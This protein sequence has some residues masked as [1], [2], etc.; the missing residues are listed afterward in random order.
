MCSYLIEV[1]FAD[2]RLMP[3][4]DTF[5]RV[6]FADRT[7][8]VLCEPLTLDRSVFA[9]ASGDI[10]P[11]NRSADKSFTGTR[12]RSRASS[13]RRCTR[14]VT[15]C[16][17]ATSTSSICTTTRALLSKVLV[18]LI[19]I[20]CSFAACSA[21]FLF[22]CVVFGCA[23]INIF[24]TL[25]NN[26][27]EKLVYD[28]LRGMQAMGVD[29]ITSNVEYGPGQMEI[30]YAPEKGIKSG[31][32]G[33]LFYSL[34]IY[35]LLF[36][37]YYCILLSFLFLFSRSPHTCSLYVQKRRQRDRSSSRVQGLL[38]DQAVDRSFGLGLPLQP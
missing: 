22:Q 13:W 38:H 4:E 23:G 32:N 35:Y 26:F 2:S 3:F 1:N 27:N 31:D 37:T 36:I 34:L 10:H 30:V 29:I 11:F 12:A 5:C 33:V 21:L 17:R 8:R 9:S 28:I 19:F 7:A 15:S 6:P 16:C 25:R 18:V 20:S 24:S 14:W